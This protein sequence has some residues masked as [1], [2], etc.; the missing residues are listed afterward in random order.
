MK[1]KLGYGAGCNCP[2]RNCVVCFSIMAIMTGI[3]QI[4]MGAG[5]IW[6]SLKEDE[7]YIINALQIDGFKFWGIVCGAGLVVIGIFGAVTGCLKSLGWK[8]VYTT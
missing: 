3:I 7:H 6:F 5:T 2:F 1:V 4:I 8:M